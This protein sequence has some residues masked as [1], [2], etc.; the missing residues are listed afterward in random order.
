MEPK[1]YALIIIDMQ[2]DFVLPGAPAC[3]AGAYATIPRI[4]RLLDFF[5]E[6]GW[7]VFHVVREYR[8]DGSDVESARRSSFLEKKGYAVP[9]TKGCEIVDDLAPMKG[10]YLVVKKRFSAFMNTELDL[11]LRR[12]G[13]TH[14]VVCGTQYP[15]CVRAT[16]FDALAYGY[17]VINIM[18]ATS[19]Q[20]R[21][22]ADANITDLKNIGVD[23]IVLDEFLKFFCPYP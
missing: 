7:L 17:P 1:K 12:L 13:A 3:I 14:L 6:K 18:D 4:K 20:T 22:I 9:G 2:N 8:A 21:Q 11:M 23:C 5:R 19:A 16:I 15:N 10:E